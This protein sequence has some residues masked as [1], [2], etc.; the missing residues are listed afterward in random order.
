MAHDRKSNPSR[1]SFAHRDPNLRAQ[2]PLYERAGASRQVF[3]RERDPLH[4]AQLD[5]QQR[6]EAE[7][8]RATNQAKRQSFIAKRGRPQAILRPS[9]SLARGVDAAA[10]ERDWSLER[11]N[12]AQEMLY[13]LRHERST[14]PPQTTRAAFKAAR[15]RMQADDQDVA[16]KRESRTDRN[17]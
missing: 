5:D 8:R 2:N 15:R 13:A 14:L 9:L 7:R 6:T 16:H 10:F 17:R 4:T 12:A 1:A 3:E 11:R